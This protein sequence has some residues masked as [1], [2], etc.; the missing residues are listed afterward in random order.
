MTEFSFPQKSRRSSQQEVA[1]DQQAQEGNEAQD[2]A[3]EGSHKHTDKAQRPAYSPSSSGEFVYSRRPTNPRDE[4]YSS[5][6]PQSN[7]AP[8]RLEQHVA[9]D[10]PNLP[11]PD[12]RTPSSADDRSVDSISTTNADSGEDGPTLDE[13]TQ[14]ENDAVS[15]GLSMSGEDAKRGKEKDEAVQD[16]SQSNEFFKYRTS[17]AAEAM[18]SHIQYNRQK[19]KEDSADDQY[20]TV[21]IFSK[22]SREETT[23]NTSSDTALPKFPAFSLKEAQDGFYIQVGDNQIH[24]CEDEPIATPGAIQSFGCLLVV[25][26]YDDELRVMQASENVNVHLGTSV[27][28]LFKLNCL[29]DILSAESASKLH[30]VII[31]LIEL[32]GDKR[33][34]EAIH[35]FSLSGVGKE[36]IEGSREWW[37]WCAAQKATTT[38]AV[39]DM[40]NELG[41]EP[42]HHNS[43]DQGGR[44]IILEFEPI[45]DPA[46]KAKMSN[47]EIPRI[48]D[49]DIHPLY[50]INLFKQS[51]NS[52][53]D[54]IRNNGSVDHTIQSNTNST[55]DTVK[56]NNMQE[57]TD[58]KTN[59]ADEQNP[60]YYDEPY[61]SLGQDSYATLL[62]IRRSTISKSKPL[63]ILQRSQRTNKLFL[64]KLEKERRQLETLDDSKR[65]IREEE[66]DREHL[67][68]KIRRHI[69]N[70]DGISSLDVLSLCQEIDSQLAEAAEKSI[71]DLYD[72]IVGL[73][74]DITNFDRVL[75]YKF[76]SEA[77][78]KVESEL[79]NWQR[80]NEI[81]HGLHFPASDIPA[82]ARELYK[83]SK[84]R[85]LFDRDAKISQVVVRNKNDLKYPLNMSGC[86]LRAMSPIHIRYLKNMNV[87]SSLSISVVTQR[88]NSSNLFGLVSCHSFEKE[89]R[90]SFPQMQLLKMF[91]DMISRN[92]DNAIYRKRLMGRSILMNPNDTMSGSISSNKDIDLLRLFDSENLIICYNGKMKIIG[93]DEYYDD[94]KQIGKYL[95]QKKWKDIRYTTRLKREYPNIEINNEQNLS[96]L[97]YVPLNDNSKE[98]PGD[99]FIAFIRSGQLEN[100]SWAGNPSEKTVGSTPL[101]PRA[102][103]K[104]WTESVTSTAREWRPEELESASVLSAVYSKVLGRNRQSTRSKLS[105]L[106]MTNVDKD[107]EH[108]LRTPL[109]HFCSYLDMAL[110]KKEGV[111]DKETR[112]NLKKTKSSAQSMLYAVNDLIS[113]TTQS[114]ENAPV[115]SAMNIVSNV[116]DCVEMFKQEMISRNISIEIETSQI[117]NPFIVSDNRKIRLIVKNLLENAIKYNHEKGKV[118]IKL[119]SISEHETDQNNTSAIML[120]V[121]DT[122]TGISQRRLKEM[123]HGFEKLE[124]TSGT[125]SEQTESVSTHDSSEGNSFGRGL[126]QVAK[127]VSLLQA[128]MTCSSRRGEY[129]KWHVTIPLSLAS[130]SDIEDL[131]NSNTQSL[132]DASSKPSAQRKSLK[133]RHKPSMSQINQTNDSESAMSE[134]KAEGAKVIDYAPEPSE[135]GEPQDLAKEIKDNLTIKE[136]PT[137]TRLLACDDDPINNRIIA[138]R[139]KEMNVVLTDNG[140]EALDQLSGENTGFDV[141]LLDLMM[142]VCDGKECVGKI[143]S[144]EKEGRS[145][146]TKSQNGPL[147]VFAFSASITQ[148]DLPTLKEQGFNGFFLKPLHFAT[149]IEIVN[150]LSKEEDVSKF[151]YKEGKRFERGGLIG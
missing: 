1:K 80:C 43:Q 49:K 129:T 38:A 100:I 10:D 82:Q 51:S 117:E 133:A 40:E 33:D 98:A 148:N 21:D 45:Y 141:M 69:N 26:L 147:P 75:L 7:T 109:H 96:G 58:V 31:E 139:L 92:M 6:Q 89:M 127:A 48:F 84:V 137:Q 14:R 150:A 144:M 66:M 122:G 16:A 140:Q 108:E 68:A 121:H 76:D 30:D 42:V 138:R 86:A 4:V 114:E 47:A 102:S 135:H 95:K 111:F 2:L 107:F 128:K 13:E 105:D 90:V 151:Q 11:L 101:Q 142:P 79:M 52:A 125:G 50:P 83:H 74:K 5:Q 35:T 99:H 71:E 37:C 23:N 143:R 145:F 70:P 93:N 67:S 18:E 65:A 54:T 17:T 126:V 136:G 110:E 64:E 27:R 29:T 118:Y 103:F 25:E 123:F 57:V 130:Q 87:R 112:K 20:S 59:N 91:S 53:E 72:V 119:T 46:A 44:R 113:L 88:P 12:E 116:L 41:E 62:E 149:L 78:G 106:L 97:L 56:P 146:R 24:T 36:G 39:N 55:N 8:Q 3:S 131:T 115:K 19:D 61:W 120:T 60:D 94:I 124:N 73:T 22:P 63:R 132:S 77:N 15:S 9:T 104:K 32:D 81:F 85:Q 34:R 28:N 134:S